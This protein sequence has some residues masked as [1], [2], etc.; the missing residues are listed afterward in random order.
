MGNEIEVI[1]D[2]SIELF[3]SEQT[4]K[5]PNKDKKKVLKLHVRTIDAEKTFRFRENETIH[6]VKIT[7]M[8]KFGIDLSQ[9][10]Q[11]FLL[12]DGRTLVDSKT[13]EQEGIPDKAT[14]RLKNE[15]QVGCNA[16]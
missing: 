11:Y 2:Q 12:Y 4:K 15:P 8:G 10:G 16:R 3:E 6:F 1:E 9:E 5:D 14:L 7:A 13:L